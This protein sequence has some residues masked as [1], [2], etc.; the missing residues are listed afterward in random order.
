MIEMVEVYLKKLNVMKLLH[1]FS[2]DAP[3]RFRTL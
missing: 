1:L 2:A 3:E